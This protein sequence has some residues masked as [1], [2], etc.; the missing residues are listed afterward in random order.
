MVLKQVAEKTLAEVL[1]AKDCG[2]PGIQ[3]HQRAISFPGSEGSR[4]GSSCS[5][6]W[7]K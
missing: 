6:N 2:V 5:K 1:F 3:P 7:P 4:G